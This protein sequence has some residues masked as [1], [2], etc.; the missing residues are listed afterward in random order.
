MKI[1]KYISIFLSLFIS[2][3][4][5]LN[6]FFPLDYDKIFK[7]TSKFILNDKNETIRISLSKDG[8]FRAKIDLNEL[9][10]EAKKALIYFEDRY[11]YYHFGINPLSIFRAIYHNFTNKNSVG[12][13][14]ITM[15]IA[16]MIEPKERTLKSKI[17]EVFRALQLEYYFSKDE[18]IEIYF[19]IAP[20]GGNI[21]GI[22]LASY[23]YFH[24]N[25]KNL[26]IFEIALL[27]IIPKNPNENRVDSGKNL[28][29]KAKR[30][31]KLLKE[32]NIISQNSYQRAIKERFEQKK[33]KAIFKHKHFT[34]LEILLNS[35]FEIIHSTLNSEL[36]IYLQKL[37]KEKI[38]KLKEKNINNGAIVVI[39]NDA[40]DIK[41]YIGSQEFEGFDGQNDGV[42]AKRSVGST[43]KPFIYGLA[44]Q[45][46]LT[47]PKK[48]LLDIPLN[49][50]GF[51]PRNFDKYYRGV[52]SSE[53]A[54]KLSLN[55]PFIDLN[56]RLKDDSI[57]ELLKE[58]GI[59]KRDKNYY[60]T[61]IVL[62]GF[63]MSL[64]ELTHLYTAFANGGIL[65]PLKIADEI[66]VTDKRERLFSKEITYIVSEILADGYRSEF[67][68]YWDS[69]INPKVAFK[70]GTSANARDLL[71]IGYTKEFTIG[72]WLGN[73]DNSKT[74]NLT[75]SEVASPIVFEI[76]NHLA[77]KQKLKWFEKP[78]IRERLICIDP[79][80]RV[81]AKEC[82][83]K[84][85][86][87]FITEV[88]DDC[89]SLS[90]Q[91]I[92]FL[93]NKGYF[94]S[95]S[96]CFDDL[97]TKKPLITSPIDREVITLSKLIPKEFQKIELKCYS[98][99]KEPNVY[100]FINN[101]FYK[102]SISGE[103]IFK[104]YNRGSY[105]IGCL[106]MNSNYTSMRLI[107]K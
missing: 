106:D 17:I 92:N 72:I 37:L 56:L 41:A 75:G 95:I 20:Y 36:Q 28:K 8:Y 64:L 87:Y 57:Y 69:T 45:N 18:L 35:E 16:R 83:E 12:A 98:Y 34:S 93:A 68:G 54:L 32:A 107:V 66:K 85:I 51:V 81:N 23:F 58:F 60:G 49:F 104:A 52:I 76:F 47:S 44:L 88:R 105:E 33:E 2:L 100:F 50:A 42:Q 67:L 10:L 30:V 62:G 22:K 94:D 29:E 84:S 89:K 25:V 53:E 9:P 31:L 1:L 91:K 21:E 15:Q 70:T 59:V 26:S 61:S 3:F 19:N 7:P 80:V 99:Q 79:F 4:F 55:T 14:T 39:D 13:S 63:G 73:F 90:V 71:T 77:T 102:E 6:H 65:K 96:N 97:K 11:F 74:S 38:E 101:K 43:L 27:S 86:D 5:I 103:A 40:M 82:K 48:R 46:G 78:K 24:K